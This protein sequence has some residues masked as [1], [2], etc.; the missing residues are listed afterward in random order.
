MKTQ[1]KMEIERKAGE[2]FFCYSISKEVE[3]IFKKR[4]EDIRE[5]SSWHNMDG[6]PL[7]FYFI[8]EMTR[9]DIYKRLLGEYG[10]IDDFGSCGLVGDGT[11]FNIGFIRTVGGKGKIKINSEVTFGDVSYGVDRMTRFLKKYHEEFLKNY[12]VKGLI[13]FE[14]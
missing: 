5:S 9:S 7:S 4:A 2:T 3:K 14:V 11:T 12:K 13:N 10:L 1:I 8:P 6:T